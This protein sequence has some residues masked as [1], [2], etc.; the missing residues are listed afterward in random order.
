MIP[1]E[2]ATGDGSKEKNLKTSLVED[3]VYI[4]RLFVFTVQ[5]AAHSLGLLSEKIAYKCERVCKC[6][7]LWIPVMG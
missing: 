4:E 3:E 1:N 7:C 6:M 5:S 2:P